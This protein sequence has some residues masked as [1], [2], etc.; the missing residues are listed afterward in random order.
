MTILV[1]GA[2]GFLGA[3]VRRRLAVEHD[4]AGQAHRH[5]RDGLLACDLR[6]AA[7]L[8]QLLR[9]V[10]PDVVVHAAA[11]REPD[12]CEEHPDEAARVNV[13]AVRE[14]C[15]ALPVPARMI[16]ISSDYVFD[17]TRPPYREDATRTPLNAYGRTKVAGEDAVL[18][19]PGSLVVRIPVLVGGGPTLAQSGYVGQLVATVR[20]KTPV[21]QD[22]VLV[23]VPTWIEDVA[24]A[25]AFLIAREATGI[26]HVAGPSA[27]TRYESVV[28][29][30]ALLGETHAHIQPSTEVVA[31]R[32][33]RPVNARL[34]TDRLRGMGYQR[35]TELVDVVRHV[36]A[37]LGDAQAV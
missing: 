5:A 6:D 12:F 34:A 15:A 1:T 4:A 24:D 19:R 18:A 16:F 23:R 37:T 31:R 9:E 25:L 22:H 7:A 29:V 27:A 21:V 28:A 8:R 11:Y 35:A 14:V 2:S 32:A 10:K 20:D 26:V 17:G 33:P 13:D 36:L 3:A 30:A